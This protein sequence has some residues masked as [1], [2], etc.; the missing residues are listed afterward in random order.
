[1][2]VYIWAHEAGRILRSSG[3]PTIELR[4]SIVI[5]TGR[6]SFEA[7]RAI[8]ERLPAIP[9]PRWVETAAQPIAV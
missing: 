3:V 7:M 1:M 5:G 9:A 6:G 2:C 8:V 4:A